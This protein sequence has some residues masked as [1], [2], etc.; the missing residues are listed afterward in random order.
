MFDQTRWS[1]HAAVPIL[2]GLA[3]LWFAAS[4]GLAGF[5]FS[6]IPGCLLLASGVSILL[7]PGDARIVSFTAI[8]GL[9]GVPL[10]LPA[11]VVAGP[12]TALLLIG[13]SA[14]SFLAAGAVAVRWEPH[15]PDVPL[16]QPSLGL[17]AHV[18]A[19]EVVLATLLTTLPMVSGGQWRRIQG[20]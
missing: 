20:E 18:A 9:L 19:D 17:S 6:M 5:V 13:L 10:A 14:A 16:P 7:W 3:W 8:G 12:G 15:T 11:F 1:A 2:G 4:F